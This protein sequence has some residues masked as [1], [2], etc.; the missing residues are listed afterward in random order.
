M[1]S[2]AVL[3]LHRRSSSELFGLVI[4]RWEIL[5]NIFQS[6][7]C[8]HPIWWTKSIS[9]ISIILDLQPPL[10]H[11]PTQQ[12]RHQTEP[13]IHLLPTTNPDPIMNTHRHHHSQNP[14]TTATTQPQTQTQT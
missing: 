7:L 3:K 12:P 14:A 4:G 10:P 9:W 5:F 8:S 1:V 2:L 11:E 13:Q 6:L